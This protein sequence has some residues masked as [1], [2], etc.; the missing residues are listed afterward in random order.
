[1]AG[2]EPDGCL[3]CNLSVAII[4]FLPIQASGW[5]AQAE[6][7]QAE[8]ARPVSAAVVVVV[9][10]YDNNGKQLTLKLS[11]LASQTDLQGNQTGLALIL[12]SRFKGGKCPRQRLS[13]TKN[14]Q[15]NWQKATANTLVGHSSQV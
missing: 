12:C 7:S 10:I 4:E 11:A 5:L 6:A 9:M 2:C 13:R 15:A 3:D 14:W 8:Q 1:M